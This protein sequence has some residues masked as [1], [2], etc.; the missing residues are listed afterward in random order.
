MF[1]TLVTPWTIVHQ[2]RLSVGFSR[3]ECWNRLPF[4]SPGH[5]PTPGIKPEFP[6]LQK[7]S[8]LTEL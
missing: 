5:L 8:L 7:D 1:L 3:Q 6:A 2:A 4:P